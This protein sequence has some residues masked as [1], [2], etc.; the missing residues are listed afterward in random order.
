[1]LN[2]FLLCNLKIPP[3]LQTQYCKQESYKEAL[4]GS[5]CVIMFPCSNQGNHV[6]FICDYKIT[7]YLYQKNKNHITKNTIT[8]SIFC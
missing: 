2:L 8:G 4:C 5:Q 1:M 7:N 6:N 3:K